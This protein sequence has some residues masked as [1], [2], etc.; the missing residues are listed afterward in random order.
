MSFI[1]IFISK[2]ELWQ[3]CQNKIEIAAIQMIQLIKLPP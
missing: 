1:D 2:D 3:M